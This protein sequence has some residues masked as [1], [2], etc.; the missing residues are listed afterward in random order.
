MNAWVLA[1]SV[2]Q[3]TLET[4]ILSKL[5]QISEQLLLMRF[6]LFDKPTPTVLLSKAQRPD[7]SD[8]DVDGF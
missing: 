2:A 3:Q 8:T 4:C 6:S 7:S 5:M 1:S